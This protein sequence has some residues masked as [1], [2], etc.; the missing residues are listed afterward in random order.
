MISAFQESS[1]GHGL[2]HDVGNLLD[3]TL[4]C[5]LCGQC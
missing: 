3:Q 5:Y 1:L 2:T 4:L